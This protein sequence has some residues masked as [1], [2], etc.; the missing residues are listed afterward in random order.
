MTVI[1]VGSLRDL[2]AAFNREPDLFRKKVSRLMIFIGE[3]SAPTLE[4][5]VGLD[6]HA[7]ICIMNSGLPV[8]WVPCFDGGNFK[9]KGNASYWTAR[10]SDLLSSASA[11]R[12]TVR[13]LQ[14][15]LEV[16]ARR[17]CSRR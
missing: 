7:F 14:P 15:P 17:R 11:W 2:A 4:W 5:N 8:W 10:H 1:T 6:P 13:S 9:N 12:G 3:A 16:T